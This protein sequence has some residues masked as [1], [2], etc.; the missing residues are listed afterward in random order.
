MFDHGIAIERPSL[1]LNTKFL[2]KKQS[3]ENWKLPRDSWPRRK[4]SCS[5][6][7]TTT[8]WRKKNSRNLLTGE[9]PGRE[10]LGPGRL[11]WE[12]SRITTSLKQI[13]FQSLKT[14]SVKNKAI[15]LKFFLLHVQSFK[16]FF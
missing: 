1:K 6:L 3:S 4:K 8:R 12:K 14:I 9:R 16:K 5:S 10:E 11:I 15:Q 13:E 7:T 2:S